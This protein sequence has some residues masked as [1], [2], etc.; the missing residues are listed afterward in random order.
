MSAP[1]SCIFQ[2]GADGYCSYHRYLFQRAR[3]VTTATIFEIA[4]PTA[5]VHHNNTKH[6]RNHNGTQRRMC[7]DCGKTYTPTGNTRPDFRGHVIRAFDLVVFLLS[8]GHG[9]AMV[10]S[11]SHL[12][13][14]TVRKIRH[15]SGIDLT[16]RCACG[17]SLGHKGMCKCR[18]SLNKTLGLIRAGAPSRGGTGQ[19]RKAGQKAG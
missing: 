16:E 17:R 4:R 19:G 18:R 14:M 15:L 13:Q 1:K 7:L 10:A 6:G 5:C 11:L 8:A 3:S 12:S 9:V 2:K